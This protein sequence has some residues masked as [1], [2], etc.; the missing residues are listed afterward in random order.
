MFILGH[1]N[2]QANCSLFEGLD[3][4]FKV[5]L[6]LGFTVDRELSNEPVV[7]GE[8]DDDRDLKESVSPHDFM[9]LLDLLWRL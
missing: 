7:L 1:R 2:I 8:D 5:A 4:R 9:R 6:S 3:T